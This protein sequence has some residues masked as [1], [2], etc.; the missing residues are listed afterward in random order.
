MPSLL[1]RRTVLAALAAPRRPNLLL[2]LPDQWRPDWMPGQPNIPLRFPNLEKLLARGV[3]FTHA[4]TPSPL[5]APARACLASGLEYQRCGVA[6]NAFNYPL[7]QTT[8]YQLLRNSG[9]HVIGCGK[10]DLHKKTEDWGVDGRRLVREWGFSDAIDNA[11]KM[12]AVRSGV[13]VPKDPYMKLLH[14]HGKAEV[15]VKDMRERKG[16][17][18]THPTPL[19]DSLYC[20]NFITGNALTLLNAAPPDKPW[21]LAVNFT[22]PHNPVDITARMEKTVRDRPYP[23]PNRNTE[24]E[25]THHVAIRQNYSAM[26]ENIDR[27]IGEILAAVEKRGDLDNTIVIFSSDHGEMLGDHNRWGKHV[28]YQASVG[29]PMVAAGPGV[30]ARGESNALVSLL[31]LTATFLDYAGVKKPATMDSRSLRPL[32]TGR[33]KVH[34]SHV[35]SALEGW[36]MVWDGRHKLIEGYEKEAQLFDLLTDP[37]ENS[38]LSAQHSK[39]RTHLKTLLPG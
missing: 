19:P 36:R 29:I 2:L 20:D 5:C 28:P 13:P 26:C 25:A 14:D 9:Y 7:T 4:I 17:A 12:D 32:L 34:R 10:L 3:K 24:F 27:G 11:G 39:I 35:V 38:N 30:K 1:S 37:L 31:D 18:G 21:H 15:H 8:Y 6:S 23:Q 16:Y 33:T 22:G